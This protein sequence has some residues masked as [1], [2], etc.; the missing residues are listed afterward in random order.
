MSQKSEIR[1]LNSSD[2]LKS[3]LEGR[4]TTE[5]PKKTDMKRQRYSD[6]LRKNP[7]VNNRIDKIAEFFGKKPTET[8]GILAQYRRLEKNDPPEV[9]IVWIKDDPTGLPYV[10]DPKWLEEQKQKAQPQ[11]P[12]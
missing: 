2:L 12:S 4:T 5:K 1:Q 6:A 7:P 11:T 10:F 9:T 3:I 8:G